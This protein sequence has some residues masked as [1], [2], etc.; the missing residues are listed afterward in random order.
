MYES[1]Y[2]KPSKIYSDTSFDKMR[3]AKLKTYKDL[4]K[5]NKPAKL[6]PFNFDLHKEQNALYTKL[7]NEYNTFQAEFGGID[8]IRSNPALMSANA[9]MQKKITDIGD[10]INNAYNV[11]ATLDVMVQNGTADTLDLSRPNQAANIYTFQEF[12][13]SG[14]F[15]TDGIMNF[16]FGPSDGENPYQNLMMT[17][18]D[19]DEYYGYTDVT[20]YY[21][22]GSNEPIDLNND[23]IHDNKIVGYVNNDGFFVDKINGEPI[24]NSYADIVDIN[25]DFTIPLKN[26]NVFTYQLKRDLWKNFNASKVVWNK[27]LGDFTYEGKRLVN[28][29]LFDIDELNILNHPDVVVK[30][31]T[32]VAKTITSTIVGRVTDD[33][34]ITDEAS[35]FAKNWINENFNPDV[36]A[37]RFVGGDDVTDFIKEQLVDII[38]LSGLNYDQEF[39]SQIINNPYREGGQLHPYFLKDSNGDGL[40]NLT[41]IKNRM[42]NKW[43]NMHMKKQKTRTVFNINTYKPDLP[44]MDIWED[45]PYKETSNI[46]S[47]QNGIE[48]VVNTW[49][50]EPKLINNKFISAAIFKKNKNELNTWE[51]FGWFFPRA[52]ANYQGLDGTLF[53]VDASNIGLVWMNKDTGFPLSKEEFNNGV[54]AILVPYIIANATVN[55]KDNKTFIEYDTYSKTHNNGGDMNELRYLLFDSKGTANAEAYVSLSSVLQSVHKNAQWYKD[56]IKDINNKQNEYNQGG[57]G[58]NGE[59]D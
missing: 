17:E 15:T 6:Y 30:N 54:E 28:H 43:A 3:A 26:S 57:G 22:D 7:I 39:F 16:Y 47:W 31:G 32:E 49:N 40:N 19:F 13:K 48:S 36:S 42:Y 20:P 25:G 55:A 53:D 12:R 8:K 5:Q 37:N 56:M 9:Q 59:L 11:F 27:K 52:V 44:W 33:N 21:D 10:Y 35:N 29:P 46:Q 51:D 14:K 2:Y 58:G 23:D 41:E 1:L 18:T 4:L 34:G 45:N 38:G 24:P 50:P